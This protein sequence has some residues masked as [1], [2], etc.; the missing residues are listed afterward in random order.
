ML[1]AISFVKHTA[2]NRTIRNSAGFFVMVLTHGWDLQ[3]QPEGRKKEKSLP[4]ATITTSTNN[5]DVIEE[6]DLCKTLRQSLCQIIGVPD[7]QSWFSRTCWHVND[8][9]LVIETPSAFIHSYV[10]L[11]WGH[12]IQQLLDKTTSQVSSCEFVTA[13]T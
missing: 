11:Q 10:S 5:S 13:Q 8:S 7:Y 12:L 1:S 3:K 6:D 9:K 4:A 2:K